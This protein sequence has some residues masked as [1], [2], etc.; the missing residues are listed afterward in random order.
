MTL[1]FMVT[2]SDSESCQPS[3]I[4]LIVAENSSTRPATP[5]HATSLVRD[6]VVSGMVYDVKSGRV[7]VVAPAAP[8]RA[9]AD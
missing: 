7:E 5:D 6:V 8:L 9:A 1:A 2:A 4:S 3:A